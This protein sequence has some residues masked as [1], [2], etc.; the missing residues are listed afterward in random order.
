MSLTAPRRV[1]IVLAALA[2]AGCASGGTASGGGNRDVVT[3]S[4][5]ANMEALNAYEALQRLKPAWL[6]P[7]GTSTLTEPER[8]GIRVYLDR[9]LVGDTEA[10]KSVPVRTVQE[11]RFLD[12]R[13]A[14]VEFG[15]DHGFGAILVT[16]R[17]G[18]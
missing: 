18:R 6:R 5:L 2:L 9:V 12:S 14:T 15:T 16:T 7:R 17:R 10:L 3:E 11:I 13:M 4:Q 8:E 1:R